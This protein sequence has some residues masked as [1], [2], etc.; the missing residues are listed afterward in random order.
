[1]KSRDLLPQ[2][3]LCNRREV[4]LNDMMHQNRL[5]LVRIFTLLILRSQ[6]E[7]DETPAAHTEA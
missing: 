4:N 3:S 2:F 6:E 7:K 5:T 1:M